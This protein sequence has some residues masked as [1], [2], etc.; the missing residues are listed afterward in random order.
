MNDFLKQLKLCLENTREANPPEKENSQC[1][2]FVY[3]SENTLV[4]TPLWKIIHTY[5][6]N[7]PKSRIKFQKLCFICLKYNDII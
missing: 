4:H 2:K 6:S 3:L 1:P 7:D 5:I